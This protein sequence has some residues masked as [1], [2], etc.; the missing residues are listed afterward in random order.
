MRLTASNAMA[1]SQHKPTRPHHHPDA[2]N[3]QDEVD[4]LRD[5]ACRFGPESYLGPWILDSLPWLADQIL[6]DI[7]PQTAAAMALDAERIRQRIIENAKDTAES[8]V[9]QAEAQAAVL[10][11]DAKRNAAAEQFRIDRWRSQ[12]QS[13]LARLSASL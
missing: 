12:A 13:D 10:I 4:A 9:R 8:I 3:K 7:Q 6:S 1:Y 11:A 2:M 5:L